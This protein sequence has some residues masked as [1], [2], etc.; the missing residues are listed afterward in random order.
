MADSIIIKSRISDL[1]AFIRLV[2]LRRKRIKAAPP[3]TLGVDPINAMVRV[4]H[5]EV[6]HLVIAGI[7]QETDT[8]RTFRL[9]PDTSRGTTAL[10]AFR[11]G[12]YLNVR[13]PVGGKT[14]TRNY[15]LS[16]TPGDAAKG[17]YAVTIRKK[18]GGFA[19]GYIFEHWKEGTSVESSGPLGTFV[20][21]GLRDSTHVVAITGGCG[22]TPIYSMAKDCAERGADVG[23]T[24]IYGVRNSRD[25]VFRDQL[26]E[27]ERG[28]AG[29]VK[30]HCVASEPEGDWKG[31]TGFITAKLISELSGPA[32]G[33]SYFVCGP[34]AMY[35]F[36]DREMASLNLPR[37]LVRREL[38]GEIDDPSLLPGYPVENISRT[39]SL[40]VH[41]ADEV[42]HI[43]ASGAET[44]LVALERAGLDP[45]SRCRSGE[46]GWCR[47]R[48][49]SGDIF[50]SPMHDGRRIADRKFNWVHPCSSYPLSDVEM[51]V[52]RSL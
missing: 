30:V 50:I 1:L 8:T 24:V 43:D 26:A 9:E 33:K 13:L 10:A 20:Y 39:H 35:G 51:R 34:Q 6:M 11:A 49:M 47:A 31:C 14:V 40:T 12:Q 44:L 32:G 38:F 29:K 22:I 45:P 48:L 46:C 4:M 15:S 27:L 28:S 3:D 17:F 21:E 16:S 36:L 19:T 42:F 37:R 41:V 2:S 7:T 18:E 5:P 25:I 52:S 23:F